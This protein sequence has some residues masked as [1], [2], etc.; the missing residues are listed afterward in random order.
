L[1]SPPFKYSIIF[2]ISTAE[3]PKRKIISGQAASSL[4]LPQSIH[5]KILFFTDT[6]LTACCLAPCFILKG[7]N[8]GQVAF[9][10]FHICSIGISLAVSTGMYNYNKMLYKH[11]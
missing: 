11:Q 7:S 5:I 1:S 8:L 10:Q 9:E 2:R 3:K 6:H 4:R